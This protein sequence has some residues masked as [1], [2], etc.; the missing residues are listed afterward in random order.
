MKTQKHIQT[1]LAL[2][3]L[4]FNPSFV[5]PAAALTTFNA[6]TD[7]SSVNGNPNGVWS[8]GWMPVDFSSFNL[9]TNSGNTD[10]RIGW[11]GW[12]SDLSPQVLFNPS[13]Q[14]SYGVPPGWLSM[15]PGPETQPSVI[16]WTAPA[17][18]HVNVAGQFLPGDSG[19]MQVAVRL[20]N[21]S[22]W[23]AADSGSYDLQTGVVAGDTIDFTVYGGFTG[24]NTPVSAVVSYNA[25]PLQIKVQPQPHIGYWGKSVTFSV[26]AAG[27]TP[28]YTHKWLKNSVPISGATGAQLVLSDLKDTDA[29][30]YTVTVTDA[31]NNS[32]TS[33]PAATLTVLPDVSIA[34]YAGLTIRGGVGQTFG[35]QATTDMTASTWI[36]VANV[37]LT[38]PAQVWYDSQSTAQQPRRFYRVVA[39]PI[40]IP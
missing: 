10:V 11:L 4:A 38:Q 21:Q 7:F 12:A 34:T 39:G 23:S 26:T 33:Q 19:I 37:T 9:Y 5:T 3:A 40:S 1:A 20:N 14:E 24:G 29:G 17:N 36:G 31:D 6:T 13:V 32:L 27:G 8:Y 22:W 30:G 2:L 25:L 35:I 28:P 18:G 16:R 15:H